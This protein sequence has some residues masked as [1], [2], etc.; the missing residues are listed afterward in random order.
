[1]RRPGHPVILDRFRGGNLVL[2]AARPGQG[3]TVLGLEIAATAARGGRPA[4]FFSSECSE[5]DVRQKLRESGFGNSAGQESPVLDLADSI[6]ARRVMSR[7]ESVP[8]GA[9]AIIDYLQV[10][11]QDRREPPVGEQVAALRQ[12][13]RDRGHTIM[14]LSQ[15]HRSFDPRDHPLPDFRDLRTTNPLDLSL[16]DAGCFLHEGELALRPGTPA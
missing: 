10:M 16:F 3:K 15:V 1:L 5:T 9:V 2:L 6:C 14:F 8:P 11:D 13:A 4:T 12:F 7:L